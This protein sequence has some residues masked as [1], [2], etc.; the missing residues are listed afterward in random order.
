MLTSPAGADPAVPTVLRAL[1]EELDVDVALVSEFREGASVLRW[2]D[3]RSGP[4]LLRPGTSA[5]RHQ[6]YAHHLAAGAIP[7]FSREP[8]RH[9][10]AA[11]LPATSVL[12]VGTYLGA[13]IE[14]ADGRTYGAV[15]CFVEES[16][17]WYDPRD[18]AVVR[19][20][21]RLVAEDVHR[22][23][24]RHRRRHTGGR[25]HLSSS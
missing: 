25:S 18:L 7:S 14:L 5:P 23:R 20:A 24:P 19:V 3:A 4:G 12:P 17:D 9:P 21:A 11:R 6:S 8:S 16:S 2:L 22:A 10:I 13:P 15:L 1:R